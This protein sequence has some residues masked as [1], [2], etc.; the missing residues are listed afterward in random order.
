MGAGVA[1]QGEG[2]R[3]ELWSP[4][5][6]QRQCLDMRWRVGMLEDIGNQLHVPP[7][8]ACLMPIACKPLMQPLLIYFVAP[9]PHGRPG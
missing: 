2:E 7:P 4:L 9:H 3:D 6:M 8:R 1:P 5:G